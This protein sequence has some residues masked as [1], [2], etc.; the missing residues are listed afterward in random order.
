[1]P[2]CPP[3]VFHPMM[4]IIITCTT[5]PPSQ[6]MTAPP[7]TKDE[8]KV[9]RDPAKNMVTPKPIM[10]PYDIPNYSPRKVM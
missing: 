9:K 1:M 3:P 10:Y 5:T 2:Y 6:E 7:K 4:Q 8:P